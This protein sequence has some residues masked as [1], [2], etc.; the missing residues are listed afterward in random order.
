MRR[1]ATLRRQQGHY[2][3]AGGRDK[4]RVLAGQAG[5]TSPTVA[6][7]DPRDLKNRLAL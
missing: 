7:W 6:G 2:T 1:N 4:A 3:T 5:T